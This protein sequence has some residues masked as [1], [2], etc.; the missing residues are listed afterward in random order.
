MDS[1][2]IVAETEKVKKEQDKFVVQHQKLCSRIENMA[3]EL[4]AD[5]VVWLEIFISNMEKDTENLSKY[6]A[7]DI[8]KYYSLFCIDT[9]Q[10]A[11]TKCNEYFMISLFDELDKVSEDIT[12]QL[13]NRSSPIPKFTLS[14][15]NKTWTKADTVAFATHRL[16]LLSAV[17]S[18]GV[19]SLAVNYFAGFSVRKI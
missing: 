12:K 5:T 6:S 17:S 8:K 1:E 7:E 4:K 10:E 18:L 3:E 14:L 15:S 11:V 19:V 13:Y 2:Q 16:P 9:I